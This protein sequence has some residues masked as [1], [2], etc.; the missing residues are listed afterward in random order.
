MR[1]MALVCVALAGI[2]AAASETPT[3]LAAPQ[4]EETLETAEGPG[5]AANGRR[6]PFVRPGFAPGPEAK[7]CSARGLEG[8]RARELALRGIVKT[9]EGFVALLVGPRGEAHVAR[10]GSRLCD[11]S[12]RAIEPAGV[13][14]EAEP[15]PGDLWL[16]PRQ[17]RVRLHPD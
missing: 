8:V 13:T 11:G 2:L 10:V 4:E 1:A 14:L 17:I 3:L 7:S 9:K 15:G 16:G 6:D 12:V 5:Y